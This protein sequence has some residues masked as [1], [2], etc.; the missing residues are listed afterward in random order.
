MIQDS[1][2][3]LN[4]LQ[5]W[6]NNETDSN[7]E[8]LMKLGG[9]STPPPPLEYNLP[10]SSSF[11][12]YAD[13]PMSIALEK[14][15]TTAESIPQ[16]NFFATVENMTEAEI[17]NAVISEI[18][19]TSASNS[20]IL[21]SNQMNLSQIPDELENEPVTIINEANLNTTNT[22]TDSSLNNQTQQLINIVK[23][24][25]QPLVIDTL[26]NYGTKTIAL[27]APLT[28]IPSI[29]VI[30][31]YTT[32]SYL[33]NYGAGKAVKTISLLPGEK[34]KITIKTYKDEVS[35]QTKSQN[36]LDSFSEESTK[37][38]EKLLEN[39][40]NQSMDSSVETNKSVSAS[41]SG[42]LGKITASVGL[43]KS[44]KATESRASNV[45]SISK[46]LDKQVTNSNSTRKIEV[47]TT[48]TQEVKEGSEE[49]IVREFENINKS[50]VLN[51]VFRQLLQEYTT[52]T[53]LSNI[54]IA[55]SNG[56]TESMQVVDVENIS[57][58]LED[59]IKPEFQTEVKNEIL[60]RYYYVI[61]HSGNY[62][63]LLEKIAPT[64]PTDNPFNAV[65]T[66]G[67]YRKLTN[68]QESCIINNSH[69]VTIPGII[70][71]IQK[72]TLRTSSLI[73]DAILGQG[74]ALD[75]FNIKTQSALSMTDGL[76]NLQTL[77]KIEIVSAQPTPEAKADAYLKVF[78]EQTPNSLT[79]DQ[80]QQFYQLA[81]ALK[82]I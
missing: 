67:Y 4:S 3:T 6:L 27:K 73:A 65:N 63:K 64:Y 8:P 78:G 10:E 41:L 76:N 46:A 18:G 34:T 57:S 5:E 56:Y 66:E 59:K 24:K 21:N 53:Y 14:F 31:E 55:F 62:V 2:T 79:T 11:I 29:F 80:A 52:V 70:L 50:R 60:K 74:E 22:T 9:N 72:H 47:N 32:S 36:V 37:E 39:E 38:L 30:E 77:Q 49:V 15:K 16:N 45:K 19:N 68:T 17:Q 1:M 7:K 13:M 25:Q 28:P 75:S 44:K 26:G 43:Q 82:T 54:K 71:Q 48:T 81:K 35:S 23:Q 69:T 12:T 33:G 20:L 58:L 42:T 40:S 51:F 61:N